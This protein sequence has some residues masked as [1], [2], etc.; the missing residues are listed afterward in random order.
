NGSDG[1][2]AKTYNATWGRAKARTIPVV[3]NHEYDILFAAGY[4]S[5]WGRPQAI[6]AAAT[7]ASTSAPGTSSFSTVIVAWSAAERA[8]PRRRGCATISQLT[9]KPARW[10]SGTS[11]STRLPR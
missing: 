8:A 1:D 9:R 7:T 4:Y 10:P 5:Y 11:P 3:G 6:L 2:F